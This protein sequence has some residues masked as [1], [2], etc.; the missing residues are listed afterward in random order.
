LTGLSA[1]APRL[2]CPHCVDFD[3]LA[4]AL[5]RS[6]Y[7][8]LRHF[9]TRFFSLLTQWMIAATKPIGTG[10]MHG[11]WRR[12]TRRASTAALRFD[13][14]AAKSEPRR[15]SCKPPRTTRRR[16]VDDR[17]LLRR[18]LLRALDKRTAADRIA[19]CSY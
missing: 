5:L 7:W 3:S 12:V 16:N 9:S 17:R 18:P 6:K 19:V 13:P 14:T 1:G 11:L 8:Q 4:T 10:A 2:H 15:R